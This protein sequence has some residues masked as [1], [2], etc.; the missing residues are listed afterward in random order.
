VIFVRSKTRKR[1][2]ADQRAGAG[3]NLRVGA[4]SRLRAGTGLGS[5]LGLW[6]G[7]LAFW[8][9]PCGA[10]CRGE[11]IDLFCPPPRTPTDRLSRL[12]RAVRQYNQAVWQGEA[13]NVRQVWAAEIVGLTA[14][15]SEGVSIGDVEL[16][17]G[18]QDA[19][20]ARGEKGAPGAAAVDHA[21]FCD[22]L[23]RLQQQARG[24]KNELL[25]ARVTAW[26]VAYGH[27]AERDTV[28]WMY[29]KVDAAKVESELAHVDTVASAVALRGYRLHLDT[30]A[31]PADWNQVW[32]RGDAAAMVWR[33]HGWFD[34]LP[35]FGLFPPQVGSRIWTCDRERTAAARIFAP[36]WAALAGEGLGA[37]VV[38]SCGSAGAWDSEEVNSLA[39]L[40]NPQDLVFRT[41]VTELADRAVY[42]RGERGYLVTDSYRLDALSRIGLTRMLPD[43]RS[44]APARVEAG[45]AALLA[46]L[47]AD[48]ARCAKA[49]WVLDVVS[50]VEWFAPLVAVLEQT[51]E[52]VHRTCLNDALARLAWRLSTTSPQYTTAA[53]WHQWWDDPET[54]AARETVTAHRALAP[55]IGWVWAQLVDF[56]FLHTNAFSVYP[57]QGLGLTA[58]Q[59]ARWLGCQFVALGPWRT[60]DPTAD[61]ET[62]P[63]VRT[64][65][66]EDAEQC[67]EIGGP[68]QLAYDPVTRR[69]SHNLAA[70]LAPKSRL[71]LLHE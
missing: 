44:Q 71:P 40:G 59:W 33:G 34:A 28:Y 7:L 65:S 13:A 27:A 15:L 43:R 18:A 32:Q 24:A 23:E 17:C 55:P 22:A 10:G 49:V 26:L 31:L 61:P 35:D 8:V 37:L 47:G 62:S 20:G 1:R 51:T 12:A 4:G 16:S 39:P 53:K 6:L 66:T 50:P 63:W 25:A 54:A 2:S 38:A 64:V 58:H 19:Q 9:L 46:E 41:F 30:C 57:Q 68:L 48:G 67:G 29:G 11:P 36:T 3:L 14:A 52:S 56:L 70:V 60:A 45:R 42:L 69:L 5:W 21:V